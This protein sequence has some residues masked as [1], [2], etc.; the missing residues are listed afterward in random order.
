MTG[1][2]MK[3]RKRLYKEVLPVALGET[4]VLALMLA[5]YALIGRFSV[6]VLVG[7]AAGAVLAG[8]NYALLALSVDRA[9]EKVSGGADEKDVAR[10]GSAM[11]MGY[12]GR[13]ALIFIALCVLAKTGACD[14]IAAVIPLVL[15][16][17]VILLSQRFAAGGGGGANAA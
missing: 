16:Q 2:Q 10:A 11:R 7:G 13:M 5:V 9:T 8:L 4:L 3:A 17:P 6:K 14:P 15:M 1:I 12:I